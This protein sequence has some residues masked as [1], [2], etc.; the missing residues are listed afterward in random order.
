[1]KNRLIRE[2]LS[3]S[4]KERAG[5]IGLLVIIFLLIIAGK[6]IPLFIPE[7]KTDFSKWESDVN[8]FLN[9]P[10]NTIP[11][12][13]ILIS[14]TFDPN[15]VDSVTLANM[16][17]PPKVAANWL[18]YLIKGGRFRDKEGL[19][20]IF[21]MTPELFEQLDSF[22]IFPVKPVKSFKGEGKSIL[23]HVSALSPRDSAQFRTYV[24]KGRKGELLLELN[25]TDSLSLLG[26]PGIGAVLASRIIRYRNLL[27]GYY[28]VSQLREVYGIREENFQLV[29]GFLRVDP[30]EV[31]P[32]NLNFS[33]V[34]ELGRHPYVGFRMARK[35][36]RLR[37][38]KGKFSS[39]DDLMPVL[40]ADSL[41]RLIPYLKFTQ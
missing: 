29:S 25:S 26:I 35:L 2:L 6:V 4:R 19:K 32:F 12:K 17:L 16:G 34:G 7:V 15:S 13:K 22:I 1:M 40:A 33:T 10:E 38:Q 28:A 31:K 30:S 21:G 24:K 3:F 23:I 5:I 36:L 11:D 9:R 41:T 14:E 37:D 27:G 39:P 20:K 8:T 18:R